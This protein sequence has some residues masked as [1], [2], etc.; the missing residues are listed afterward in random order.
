VDALD[1]LKVCL[2]R[3]YVV[4]PIVLL[5]LAAALGLAHQ[6][7]PTYTAFGSYALVYHSPPKLK[8]GVD[9]TEPNP[10]ATN[11][12]V[13]LGE[14]LV[15]DFMSASSQATFGGVGNSGTAPREPKDG[16]SYSVTLPDGSQSYV[17]QTWGKD[18]ASLRTVVNSVLAAAPLQAAQIQDRAGAPK[19]SQY[20]TFVTGST[21]LTKLPPTSPLKLVIALLG[22][23]ILVGSALSLV[24]D[25]LVRSRKGRA[26][27]QASQVAGWWDTD[28]SLATKGSDS[29]GILRMPP[30]KN[31]AESVGEEIKLQFDDATGLDAAVASEDIVTKVPAVKAE[32][33]PPYGAE[34]LVAVDAVEVPAVDA[35]A[36][37]PADAVEVPAVG[38]DDR[39]PYGAEELVA[40]DAVEVP[41]VDA[42]AVPPADAVEVPE[43]SATD[44]L[45]SGAE[46][47]PAI[48]AAELDAAEAV[49]TTDAAAA[50]AGGR[51][52]DVPAVV[53]DEVS[54]RESEVFS[55]EWAVGEFHIDWAGTAADAD[56]DD[57]YSA[58]AEEQ[59][60]VNHA[61]VEQRH[62]L[63]TKPLPEYSMEPDSDHR[64]Q[65]SELD[66]DFWPL[67]QHRQEFGEREFKADDADNQTRLLQHKQEFGVEEFE[68]DDADNQTRLLQHKQEFGVEEF[69]ADDADNQTRLLQHKQEFGV[70]EFDADDADNQTRTWQRTP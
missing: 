24:V 45:P 41:A 67:L 34:E 9:P 14:A 17:V 31:E 53:P 11:G 70:E 66:D 69:D 48:E 36:A 38:V 25:R 64:D 7:K 13:V 56:G 59:S 23:G 1:V 35:D 61:H 16:T 43:V 47:L 5:S 46:E 26:A 52:N 27:A 54:K 50:A 12:A 3:W 32:D 15:A 44:R 33:R 65:K 6:Q 40:V 20:T 18:P 10:L 22:V 39:P 37:P 68:A 62:E 57:V 42:E 29:P 4:L 21:Q 58:A 51:A 8:E 19:K 49:P 60:Q 28:P 55:A 30:H 63:E 2:R